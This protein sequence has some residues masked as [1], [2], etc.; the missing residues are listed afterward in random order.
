MHSSFALSSGF[1]A[2]TSGAMQQN[3]DSEKF[4]SHERRLSLSLHV[5]TKVESHTSEP[6]LCQD[7]SYTHRARHTAEG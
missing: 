4:N 6:D 5:E 3:S 1:F 7:T 2:E